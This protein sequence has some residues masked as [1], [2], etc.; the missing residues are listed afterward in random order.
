LNFVG[1]IAATLVISAII[2][3]FLEKPVIA[4]GKHLARRRNVFIAG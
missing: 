2:Y 1:S 3:R 4:L